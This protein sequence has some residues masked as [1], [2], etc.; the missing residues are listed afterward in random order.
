MPYQIRMPKL[1][2][3][4]VEGTIGRWLKAVGDQVAL[5][6][7]IV[8]VD[9][10]KVSAEI[11]SPVAGVISAILVPEG[12]TVSV[13][14]PIAEVL[15][16]TASASEQQ[17]EAQSAGADDHADGQEE[18]SG[19]EL[20]EA[21][22]PKPHKYTPAVRH[23]ATAAGLDPGSIK[24][25]GTGGRVT[26]KDVEAALKGA[27]PSFS[28]GAP[29][30]STQEDP[31][32]VEPQRPKTDDAEAQ[33]AHA[34]PASGGKMRNIIPAE[35]DA[36][37]PV[38]RMRRH[39]AEHMTESKR[40][41]PHAWTMVEVDVTS[42]V[43]F[44]ESIKAEF[45]QREGFNLT[46]LAFVMKAAV[47]GLREYPILNSQWDGDRI[48]IRKRINLGIAVDLEDGLIVPVVKDADKKSIVGLAHAVH[49]LAVRARSGALRPE[50]VEGGTFTVNNTGAFGSVMSA[51]IINYPQAAILSME[52]IT[53]RPVVVGEGIA[54][55]SIMNLCVSLDHRILDGAV[56]GRFLRSVKRRLESY[57]ETT[58][59]Y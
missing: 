28:V 52:T 14:M 42:L 45:A 12:A 37:V 4:V 18:S 56:I 5:D 13:D 36:V 49:E 59:I 55:R 47:E 15:E 46:Y 26:R 31:R 44:R 6:E 27:L 9:T 30:G 10:D 8:E 17:P 43:R 1:G 41:V 57:D 19:E 38:T 7:P 22:T 24:G 3:S 20:K 23:I 11:P 51:P 35:G 50:D 32:Q 54:I 21:E 25:H 39:I 2:E 40:I 33:P 48:V 53:R 58:P 34:V 29:T 16:D